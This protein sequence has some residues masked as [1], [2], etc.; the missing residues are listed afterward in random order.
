MCPGMR[1]ATGA[2]G[3]L[4][5]DA[6]GDGR[7]VGADLAQRS[8]VERAN[9]RDLQSAARLVKRTTLGP[10]CDREN[11]ERVDEDVKHDAGK[12]AART[13]PQVPEAQAECGGSER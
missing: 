10:E 11:T 12:D 13:A 2:D 8:V 4:H 3:E 7:I 1:P 6:V 9:D 5:V